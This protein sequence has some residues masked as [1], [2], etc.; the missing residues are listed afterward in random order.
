VAGVRHAKGKTANSL[1]IVKKLDGNVNY[2]HFDFCTGFCSDLGF[3]GRF[4]PPVPKVYFR[5]CCP[6]ALP[7]LLP[8]LAS[9]PALVPHWGQQ[10]F[11]A[12]PAAAPASALQI[13]AVYAHRPGKKQALP[14]FLTRVAAGFPSPADDFL[15]KKIDLN[16]YCIRHPA[17]TFFVRV[18]GSR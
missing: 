10:L 14:L 5:H 11:P 8:R 18:V 15:E 16:E 13:T 3:R 12:M 2:P 4:L 6:G 17:A 7:L 1:P 9:A